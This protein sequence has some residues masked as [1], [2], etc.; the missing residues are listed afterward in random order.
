MEVAAMQDLNILDPGILRLARLYRNDVFGLEDQQE[1]G[2]DNKEYRHAAYRQ[3]ILWQHG[4]LGHGTAWSSPAAVCGG[5]G[6][7]FLTLMASTQ[8]FVAGPGQ[9]IICPYNPA[10]II[11]SNRLL[12]HILKCRKDLLSSLD[13]AYD[14]RVQNMQEERSRTKEIVLAYIKEMQE[15]YK[16]AASKRERKES[17]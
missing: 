9:S 6:G 14:D 10:H 5:S 3:Y 17:P 11:K 16:A 7:G 1:P 13:I 4:R 15:K 12:R 2:Q 8:R